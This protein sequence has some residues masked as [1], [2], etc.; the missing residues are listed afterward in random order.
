M[1]KEITGE[2][3]FEELVQQIE[4]CIENVASQNTYTPL[5]MVLIGFNIIYKC[6]FYREYCQYW[7]IKS[8]LDKTW[9]NFKF[10]FA[11]VFKNTRDSNKTAINSG[12]ADLVKK[13]QNDMQMIAN[14][15]LQD[16]ADYAHKSDIE[17][18]A[19]KTLK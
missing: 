16:L 4:D 10:R 13:N 9:P 15:N 7:R 3:H 19:T 11:R 14:E 6:G 1:K 12:Y 17:T 8:K 2:T 5:Q 18:N